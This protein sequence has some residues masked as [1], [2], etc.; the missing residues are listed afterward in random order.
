MH[1]T[2]RTKVLTANRQDSNSRRDAW[3]RKTTDRDDETDTTDQV[4]TF[5]DL[6]KGM[7]VQYKG[8]VGYIRE[9]GDHIIPESDS[10]HIK[11]GLVEQGRGPKK[12]HTNVVNRYLRE[13]KLWVDWTGFSRPKKV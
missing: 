1:A 2:A 8:T 5:D 7:R 3:Q 12:L 9:K 4:F 11:F 13:G 6:E 10:S